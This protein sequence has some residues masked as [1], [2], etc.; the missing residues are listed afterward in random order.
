MLQRYQIKVPYL[1]LTNPNFI[2]MEYI[3]G[4][5]VSELV[6]NRNNGS[7]IVKLAE[8]MHQ[9]HTIQSKSNKYVFLKGDCNLRNFIYF[10]NQ[11]YGLDFEEEIYGDP[12]LDLGEIC[13]FILDIRS[14]DPGRWQ[15]IKKFIKTYENCSGK[16]ISNLGKFINQSSKNAKKRRKLKKVSLEH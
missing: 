3:P 10:K 5:P 11:I 9:I 16:K 15:M 14:K 2:I 7:W 6:F 1:I 12:S 13:F 4:K 8:W